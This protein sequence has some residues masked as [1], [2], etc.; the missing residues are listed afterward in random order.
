[1]PKAQMKKLEILT[2][3]N[4]KTLKKAQKIGNSK[5]QVF[6]VKEK[7]DLAPYSSVH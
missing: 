3:E 2:L 1:M 6:F 4:I 7:E 5:K